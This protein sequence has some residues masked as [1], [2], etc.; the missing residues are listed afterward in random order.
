MS[1][2]NVMSTNQMPRTPKSPPTS[3]SADLKTVM[4]DAEALLQGDLGAD[5]RE[6]PGSARPR[7]GVAAPGEGAAE[8][9]SRTRRCAARARLPTR[10]TSTC[11]RIRGS[12]S[13]SPPASACCS[14]CCSAAAESRSRIAHRWQR[15]PQEQPQSATGLF[16][17][18]SNFAGTLVAHRAHAPAAAH[19]R[20]AG[21][22]AAGRRDP[23]VGVHRGVRRA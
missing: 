17:S 1:D 19:D 12:R 13:A 22:S 23:A 7:R 16:Q 14:G 5:G 3:W 15:L 2:T 4:N 8:L 21:G 10:P 20:A 6:D 11:A 9:E 18:L